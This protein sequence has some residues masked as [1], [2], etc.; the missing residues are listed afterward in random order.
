[1]DNGE[2]SFLL[3]GRRD[4]NLRKVKYI[5]RRVCGK[6]MTGL[7]SDFYP[8]SVPVLAALNEYWRVNRKVD[9]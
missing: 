5:H 6:W 8:F 7:S 2:W 1:M 9:A 4:E 3:F